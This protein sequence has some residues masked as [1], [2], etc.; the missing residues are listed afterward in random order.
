VRV[1]RSHGAVQPEPSLPAAHL[2]PG[3]GLRVRGARGGLQGAGAGAERTARRKDFYQLLGLQRGAS[4]QQMKKAYRKL[5]LQYHPVRPRL[6]AP[7]TT[8]GRI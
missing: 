2:L 4:E 8:P 1:N 7:L 5:A 3:G 6:T